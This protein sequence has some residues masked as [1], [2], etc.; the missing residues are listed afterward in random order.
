[1]AERLG[2]PSGPLD[3][4]HE[5]ASWY[6]PV[7]TGDIFRGV[8]VPGATDEDAAFDLTMIIAHPSAMRKGAELEPR[9]RAASIA[10]VQGL[11]KKKWPRGSF[12]VFPLPL[13][14]AVAAANGFD[15][16]DEQWGALLELAAPIETSQLDV[17]RRI[18]CLSPKGIHLLLQRIVHSDT[19]FPVK[20]MTLAK[21][22]SPKLE[23]L[24]MLQ[25]WNEDLVEPNVSSGADL[26]EAL[27]AAAR[28][29]EVV[30]NTGEPSLREML[31]SGTRAGEAQRLLA[32]EIRRRRDEHA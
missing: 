20:E 32:A 22:F 9:A 14:S 28:A 29:F 19:R 17:T 6:R 27:L 21:V 5:E 2:A 15:I 30:M 18:A 3:I 7:A 4:Y 16:N 12:N 10:P 1:L 24:E 25:T 31:E 11:S 23:E 8:V 13:L 26:V